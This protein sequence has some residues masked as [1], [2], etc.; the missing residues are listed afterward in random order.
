MTSDRRSFL[1]NMGLGLAA[2]S[3][4]AEGLAATPAG[5]SE[6]LFVTDRVQPTPAPIGY[7]RL[8]LEWYKATT[9]RLKDKLKS[10]GVDAILLE[11]DLNKVYFSGCFRHSG[12]RT[13]WVMFPMNEKDTAYWY[14]PA[15]DR[16][17]IRTWWC[18]ELEYYFCYPHADGGYPNKGQLVKGNTK[19]IF[20]WMLEGLRKRG[21]DGKTIG[22]DKNLSPA[23]LETAKKVLPQ[24]KWVNIFDDC[25]G[26]RIIKTPEEI[27]LF[28]RAYRYFDKVHAFSRDFVL[29]HGTNVTDFE[30][31]QALQAYAIKLMMADVKYDGRP[32]TAVG[33]DST[34]HYVRTG[35]STAYPHP[36]Q[37]FYNKVQRGQPLYINTDISLGGMG[38]EGYR[39]Y[40]I[41]PWTDKQDKLW[42]VVAETVQIMAEET[43]PGVLCCDVAYKIHQH[44]I[45]N[46]MQEF[47]YHR[48]GHGTGQ[49]GEG[50]QAPF[51]ALGDTTVIQEGMMFSVEPGMYDEAGGI[52]VNP[53][54]N[55]L[56]TKTGSVLQSRVPFSKEWSYLKV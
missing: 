36:N 3:L 20:V 22:I 41:A 12:E 30:I 15:I 9:Q 5:G 43:K 19:D 48:P 7:D 32:H 34:A 28:Q 40:L 46:G 18:T 23:Q 8:P 27:A 38:G 39:N 53:S 17:L 50:H 14:A 4:S 29:E 49:N 52:G 25:L 26:M 2:A 13:T 47:I 56:V 44:Q 6:S 35:V 21:L 45:K 33:I 51:I 37:F 31:G 54:D 24:S 55:L 16:D 11:S 1:R 42:Q 10:K